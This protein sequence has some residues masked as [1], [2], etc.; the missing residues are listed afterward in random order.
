MQREHVGE[1]AC[2]VPRVRMQHGL[3][4]NIS[5]CVLKTRV[6]CVWVPQFMGSKFAKGTA[7]RDPIN[8]CD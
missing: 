3:G 1:R 6:L 8:R 7:E 2:A 5:V 4:I